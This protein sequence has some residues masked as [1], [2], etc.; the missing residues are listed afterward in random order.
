MAYQNDDLSVTRYRRASQPLPTS[1]T[2]IASVPPELK[3]LQTYLDSEFRKLED[4]IN[5]LADAV[6]QVALREPTVKKIGMIRYAKSPWDPLGSG[7]GWVFW[8]GS[9]WAAL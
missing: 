9:A 6:P 8:D 5:T 7:D 3:K 1:G 4:S 2:L